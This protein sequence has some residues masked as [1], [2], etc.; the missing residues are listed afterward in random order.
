MIKLAV[1]TRNEKYLQQLTN[2]LRGEKDISLLSTILI[3]NLESEVERALAFLKQMIEQKPDIFL[4]DQG[5]LRDAAALNLEIILD[6][7]NK[8]PTMKTIIAGI[9]FN[10]ENVMAMMQGGVRGFFRFALGAEQLIKCIRVVARGEIWL[11]A[12]LITPV[13]DEF[14]KEFMKRRDI[15][16]PLTDLSSAKLDMLSPREMDVME[17]IS[18][19]MTNEE[20]A[21]KLFIS[22]KT[23]KTHLRNIFEKAGIKNRVEAALLYARHALT[24]S[25]KSL[26][27]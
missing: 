6:Y 21:D 11:E 15:L 17:L 25:N 13:F 22:S 8:L 10:E 16:K 1:V 20:I 4:F 2:R 27:F 26:M 5:I 12:E 19:S 9:R 14:I 18:K 7:K 24:F 23:V 3:K